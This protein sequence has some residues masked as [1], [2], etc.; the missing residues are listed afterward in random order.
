MPR[1]FTNYLPVDYRVI[2][3]AML[4]ILLKTNS[5]QEPP[6]IEFEVYRTIQDLSPNSQSTSCNYVELEPISLTVSLFDKDELAA[7]DY[8]NFNIKQLSLA[9]KEEE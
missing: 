1:Q 4:G 6:T 2:N 3:T 5:T 9:Y 7:Q 8:V